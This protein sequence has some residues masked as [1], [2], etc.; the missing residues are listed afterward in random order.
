MLDI[1][2]IRNN[3]EILDNAQLRRGK[4][5]ISK[6]LISQDTDYRQVLTELQ[7]LQTQRNQIAKSFGEAKRKG[8]DTSNL[9]KQAELIK[10]QISALEA[11]SELLAKKAP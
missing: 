4:D 8:E 11:Q 6:L 3:P 1:K 7:D 10:N 5:A 2:L 9:S